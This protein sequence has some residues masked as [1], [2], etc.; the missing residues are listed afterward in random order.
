MAGRMADMMVQKRKTG[1]KCRSSNDVMGN[2]FPDRS[3][4]R[5]K[6]EDVDDALV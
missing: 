6:Q 1:K 3:V 5:G 4:R 2:R